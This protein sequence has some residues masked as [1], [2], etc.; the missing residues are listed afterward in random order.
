M[1]NTVL[2]EISCDKLETVLM[3]EHI[4]WDWDGAESTTKYSA[5]E[6]VETMAPYLLDL[7]KY[8]CSTFVDATTFG[9]GRDLEILVKCAKRTGL[10]ILTNTGVWDGG[11]SN[12]KYTPSLLKDKSID[13]IAEIWASDFYNGIDGTGIKPAY[14]KLAMGDTGE[15]TPQ[16]EIFLRAAAR[17]SIRTN[18]PVQCHMFASSSAIQAVGIIKEEKLPLNKF[19]WVHADCDRNISAARDLAKMG[20]WVEFDTLAHSEEFSWHINAIKDMEAEGL[21]DRLLLSQDAGCFYYGR[22]NDE[23]TIFPYARI[24]KEFIPQCVENGINRE[25]FDKILIQNTLKV[26]NID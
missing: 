15:I 19:I 1:I 26:L 4:S 23:S 8:G 25:L 6:V 18:M 7:K 22:K 20:I 24:F 21:T 11:E 14:I 5:E 16:Q 12:G 10:N 3:H 13:E 9:S 2:G 17:T